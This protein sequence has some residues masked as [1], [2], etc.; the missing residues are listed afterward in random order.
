MCRG[1]H[2]LASMWKNQLSSGTIELLYYTIHQQKQQH[3]QHGD[4][5]EKPTKSDNNSNLSTPFVPSSRS[6]QPQRSTILYDGFAIAFVVCLFIIL[7]F[8][9]LSSFFLYFLFFFIHFL[10]Y[11][12]PMDFRS[13]SIRCEQ[14]CSV[15]ALSFSITMPIFRNFSWTIFSLFRFVY[16]LKTE[17]IHYI[18]YCL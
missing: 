8:F 11:L 2:P 6:S 13:A 9:S 3:Q 14:S 16:W 12:S 10:L 18:L 17:Q 15:L 1:A 7:S 4:V 5:T